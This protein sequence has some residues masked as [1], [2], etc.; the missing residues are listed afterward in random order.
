MYTLWSI[1]YTIK[2]ALT[3]QKYSALDLNCC[4]HY[5]ESWLLVNFVEEFIESL[6]DE[7]EGW[8]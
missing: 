8:A 6:E 3:G 7:D 5:H 4:T 2:N 1:L